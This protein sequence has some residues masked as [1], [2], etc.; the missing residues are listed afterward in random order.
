MKKALL[1]LLLLPSLAIAQIPE[2]EAHTY[3]NDF[4]DKLT[5]GE[6]GILNAK[7]RVIEDQSSVQIAVLILDELP[8]GMEIGDYAQE[9]GRKWHVGNARNGLVYVLSLKERK[10]FLAV[11]AGLQSQIS[12]LVASSI[13]N[14]LKSDLKAQDYFNAM[15]RLVAQIDERLKPVQ[16][17]QLTLAAKETEKKA[18]ERNSIPWGFLAL[19][20]AA[21]SGTG[22]YIDRKFKKAAKAR[23]EVEEERELAQKEREAVIEENLIVARSLQQQMEDREIAHNNAM[24]A[25]GMHEPIDVDAYI[26]EQQRQLREKQEWIIAR[27]NA[28]MQNIRPKPTRRFPTDHELWKPEPKKKEEEEEPRRSTSS[29]YIPPIIDTSS[30]SS[31]SSSSDSSSSYGSWG[32]GS[33]DSGSSDSGSSSSFD[34]GGGGGEF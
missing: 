30:Y 2:P 4:A 22:W 27:H 7:I 33:S 15:L 18:E 25:I 34:G 12:D 8:A 1:F 9:V 3:V 32:S 28:L 10:Q 21:L 14:Q 17:E 13:I 6:I 29:G 11:A 31:G 20:A 19:L 23:K 5:S 16:E 26:Q 24:A